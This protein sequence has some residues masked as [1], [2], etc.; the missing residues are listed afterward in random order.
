MSVFARASVW[1]KKHIKFSDNSLLKRKA[2]AR[3]RPSSTVATDLVNARPMSLEDRYRIVDDARHV[4]SVFKRLAAPLME[5]CDAVSTQARQLNSGRVVL[6]ELGTTD[7]RRSYIYMKPMNEYGWL[8]ERGG[9][10]WRVSR[11]EKIIGAD[12][13]MRSNADPWDLVTLWQD[14]KGE[15]LMRVK[16]QR[17]GHDLMT[18]TE[19]ERRLV[20][21]LRDVLTVPEVH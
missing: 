2:Y 20:A 19:Y 6:R 3:T 14:P 1:F 4:E 5:L 21:T 17:F 12:M 18:V 16:S 8:V 15:G 11:A 9:A 7:D 10:G 13:F